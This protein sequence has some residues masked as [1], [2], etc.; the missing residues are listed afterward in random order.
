MLN[1]SQNRKNM[2]NKNSYLHSLCHAKQSCNLIFYFLE[3]S[4]KIYIHYKIRVLIIIII[5]IQ[6]V[7]LP[8]PS[9]LG[10]PLKVEETQQGPQLILNFV[11][12][13]THNIMHTAH[14][15]AAMIRNITIIIGK[16]HRCF[17][18]TVKIV[19]I[20]DDLFK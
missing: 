10:M 8:S 16:Y 17:R 9:P 2:Q 13:R 6:N 14:E 4:I 1:Y 7:F 3:Q 19:Y 18:I 15:R 12:F 20:Q 5:F 11:S